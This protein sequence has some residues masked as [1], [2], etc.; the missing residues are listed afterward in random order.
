MNIL[1]FI[2]MVADV[3]EELKIADDFKSLDIDWIRFR[4]SETDE[5]AVE[6]AILLKEKY[7]GMVTVIALDAPEVDDALY[8][9]LAKGAD[10]AIK[11]C[12]DW[13]NFRSPGIAKLFSNYIKD[14]NLLV[15]QTLIMSG[16]QAIDDLEGELIY[17]MGENLNIPTCGIVTSVNY[18]SDFNLINVY[19]EFAGGLRGEFE[20]NLPAIIGIQAAEKPPRYIPIAK[21]RAIMKTAKIEEIDIPDD[22]ISAGKEVNRLLEPE[23]SGRATMLEGSPDE[24]TAKLIEILSE[25]AII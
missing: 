19:K 24:I 13:M 16:S 2:R 1:I 6:Q 17:Y 7:G 20:I 9:A 11:I 22:H 21:I 4:L 25:K 8:N 14:E 3:V 23:V 5:H 18:R 12:G 10:R 15:T